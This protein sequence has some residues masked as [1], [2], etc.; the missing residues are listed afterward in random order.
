VELRGADHLPW[1]GDADRVI[2]EVE[3]FLTGER[4]PA[5]SD[6]VLAT[7]VFTDIVDST[8]IAADMG[9][10]RWRELVE[11]HDAIVRRQLAAYRG[12][13]IKTLGDGFLAIFDA[14]GRAIACIATVAREVRQL[15]IDVR[16]GVHTGE[17]E[18]AGDDV[19]GIAINL[20]A[21]VGALAQAGEILVSSTV[22]DLVAGSGIEFEDR[23]VHRL[24]GLPDEWR[25]Y[26]ARAG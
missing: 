12:R 26:A 2:A 10:R 24:K 22:K 7:V 23:G 8:R 16:A 9:D 6:R 19:R 21:R 14:P 1:L 20:G 17:C 4:R 15:G 25:L 3:E 5:P 11:S 18:L 13:E